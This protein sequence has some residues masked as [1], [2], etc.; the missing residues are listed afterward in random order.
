M[1]RPRDRA[2]RQR[3]DRRAGDPVGPGFGRP[4]RPNGRRLLVSGPWR[5]KEHLRDTPHPPE[6]PGRPGRDR[7]DRKRPGR[8]SVRHRRDRRRRPG[9]QDRH[10][11]ERRSDDC[12]GR[13]NDR[14]AIRLRHRLDPSAATGAWFPADPTP[15][16]ARRPVHRPPAPRETRPRQRDTHGP[17]SRRRQR[18]ADRHGGHGLGRR[19]LRPAGLVHSRL[20]RS[21][22]RRRARRELRRGDGPQRGRV[23]LVRPKA[24]VPERVCHR[25]RGLRAGAEG[26]RLRAGAD[27]T[28]RR[29]EH[30]GRRPTP[31][32]RR[33]ADQRR[34]ARH[35]YG[36]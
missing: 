11:R 25:R 7:R 36:R 32:G 16:H 14:R 20:P 6:R 24:M 21:G 10:R 8:R 5:K 12:R 33:R 17:P 18:H 28:E 1:E 9:R 19:F 2:G 29:Q 15:R 3:R 34:P 4:G 35:L 30:R 31:P 27:R 23:R 26:L 22:P 13:A